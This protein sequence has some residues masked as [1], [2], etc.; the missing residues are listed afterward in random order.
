MNQ[1]RLL[2]ASFERKTLLLCGEIY[3][4]QFTR[5]YDVESVRCIHNAD[6]YEFI[7]L[8]LYSVG[9]QPHTFLKERQKDV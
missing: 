4:K 9:G 2:K 5:R 3:K 8:R 1:Y 7:N 6:I